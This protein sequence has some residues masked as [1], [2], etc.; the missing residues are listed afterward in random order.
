MTRN[1]IVGVPLRWL[2]MA[3]LVLLFL[4][5]SSALGWIGLSVDDP[6]A[7]LLERLHPSF[8]LVL[9]LLIF[10]VLSKGKMDWTPVSGEA[11]SLVRG[12]VGLRRAFSS[13]ALIVLVAIAASVL[14]ITHG[15]VAN[16]AT[17]FLLAILCA[18]GISSLS[19]RELQRIRNILLLLLLANSLLGIVE[20]TTG[21]RLFTYTVAGIEKLYDPRPTAW[22]S[23]PLNNALL[24]ALVLTY[25]LFAKA[26]RQFQIYRFMMIAVHAFALLCFGGRTAVVVLI[27]L[28]VLDYALSAGRTAVTRRGAI[29][30]GFKTGV[31]TASFGVLVLLAASGFLDDIILG[32]FLDDGGS[33]NVR[34]STLAIVREFDFEDA[35]LGLGRDALIQLMAYYGIPNIELSWLLLVLTHGTLVG[36]SLL[37]TLL[38]LLFRASRSLDAPTGYMILVFVIV[39]FGYTSFGTS[40]LLLAQLATMIA[41]FTGTNFRYM[42][43][44]KCG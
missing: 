43:A 25:L 7:G 30:L 24:T 41:A 13:H 19:L 11:T 16:T 33:A 21:F 1:N 39:T 29:A 5:S 12:H 38:L 36:A 8:Y 9:P 32:R 22:F 42:E 34:W 23:H 2:F 27:G 20:K 37:I 10:K 35:L 31:I 18:I 3:A 26:R 14:G 40:S 4:G 17:T 6:R 15:S 28:V 44:R